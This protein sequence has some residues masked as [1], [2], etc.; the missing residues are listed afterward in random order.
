[1]DVHREERVPLR[2]LSQLA[3]RI[4]CG[5]DHVYFVDGRYRGL[6]IVVNLGIFC[7]NSVRNGY[8]PS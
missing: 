7:L 3:T 1:M 5:A 4:Q 8:D 2:H 6:E